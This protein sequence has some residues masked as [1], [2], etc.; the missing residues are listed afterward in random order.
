M[1]A[2]AATVRFEAHDLLTR[3]DSPS[4]LWELPWQRRRQLSVS[5]R[6]IY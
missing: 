6:T 5:K 1:A 4:A 2:T 3:H